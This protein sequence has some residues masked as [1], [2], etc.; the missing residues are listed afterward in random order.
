MDTEDEKKR[1]G[2]ALAVCPEDAFRAAL[3]V[4]PGDAGRALVVAREWANDPLVIEA[5]DAAIEAAL[6]DDGP[7]IGKAGV[8]QMLL[9]IA[10]EKLTDAKDRIAALDKINEMYGYKTVG[11]GTGGNTYI[12]NRSVMIVKDHGTDDE[13]SAKLRAQQER[14]IEDAS[15]P[16]AVN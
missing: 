4:Y 6:N 15:R 1:Y 10:R 11:E 12:D 5:R 7:V 2:H 8:A 13:W 3:T 16:A 9:D 14:L